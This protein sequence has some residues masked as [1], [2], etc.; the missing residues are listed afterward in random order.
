ML[1]ACIQYASEKAATFLGTAA[2]GHRHPG[3]FF[4]PEQIEQMARENLEN[5]AFLR[6]LDVSCTP[7]E[8][9][10]L[11]GVLIHYLN[12]GADS[13]DGKFPLNNLVNVSRVRVNVRV[14]VSEMQC[15]CS[16]R[17]LHSEDCVN[18]SAATVDI[19]I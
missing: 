4:T 3:K 2:T 18:A 7:P 14:R 19:S 11:P 10:L 1:F 5:G 15:V 17:V 12:I 13:A 8:I 6:H 16:A 9:P